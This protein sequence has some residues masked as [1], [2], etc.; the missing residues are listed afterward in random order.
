MPIGFAEVAK[1][2]P[3][4]RRAASR[5]PAVLHL[6]MGGPIET[7]LAELPSQVAEER[8]RASWAGHAAL[9]RALLA[10]DPAAVL[11]AL[12]RATHD[13]ADAADL[14]RALAYAAALRWLLAPSNEHGDWETATDSP[15]PTPCTRR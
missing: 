14:A 8:S 10:D 2:F 4:P 15:T 7:A 6:S 12:T 13:G 11:A 3:S 9:G 5:A 1:A